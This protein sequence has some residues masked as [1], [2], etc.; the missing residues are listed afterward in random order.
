MNFR[1]G[2][3]FVIRIKNWIESF[4]GKGDWQKECSLKATRKQK[5]LISADDQAISVNR[6]HIPTPR[7]IFMEQCLEQVFWL[8]DHPTGHAFPSRSNGIVALCVAFVPTY[9]AGS[10][11]DFHRL[12]YTQA[13][14]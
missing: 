11:T 8:V 6:L 4:G 14:A 2:V 9:S 13:F 3:A 7:G 1:P 12:P 10:A 5:S